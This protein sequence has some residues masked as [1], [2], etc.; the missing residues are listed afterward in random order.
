[1]GLTQSRRSD[2]ARPSASGSRLTRSRGINLAHAVALHFMYY[3][4]YRIHR[5]LRVTPAMAVGVT[6]RLWG[7]EDIVKLLEAK[8]KFKLVVS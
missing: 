8:E 2:T 4:F 7:V 5:L 6:E 3:N 1:M